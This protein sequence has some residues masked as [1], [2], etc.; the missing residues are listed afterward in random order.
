MTTSAE[1]LTCRRSAV[2]AVALLASLGPFTGRSDAIR[3][4]ESQPGAV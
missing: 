4:G 1:H 3:R 2:I